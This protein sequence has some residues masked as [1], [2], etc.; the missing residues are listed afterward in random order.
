MHLKEPSWSKDNIE[1]I[2]GITDS[3]ILVIPKLKNLSDLK[4]ISIEN[5]KFFERLIHKMN[6]AISNLQRR[7][8]NHVW[9]PCSQMKD[10]EEF[11]PIVIKRGKGI[12]LYDENGKQYIDMLFPRW[13][14]L[15]GHANERISKALADQA[16][17]IRTFD[18]CQLYP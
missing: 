14:N 3:P 2:R 5:T 13:V 6:P 18:F 12:Y 11:P 9:H 10:Y 1:T 15:F 17:Q 4:T 8:L 16:F 7:D